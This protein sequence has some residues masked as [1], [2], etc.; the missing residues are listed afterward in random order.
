MPHPMDQLVDS[1]STSGQ[2][3]RRFLSGSTESGLGGQAADGA[4][5]SGADL[6]A[7]PP[8][9]AAA[10]DLD[11]LTDRV[12]RRIERRVVDELERRGR[13]GVRRTF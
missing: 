13:T 8:L 9:P 5:G 4:V 3:L 2:T 6:S 12:V 11:E 7:P 10:I 1:G